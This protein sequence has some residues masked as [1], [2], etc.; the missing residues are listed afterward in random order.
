ME[1]MH[2][3][4]VARDN[5]FDKVLSKNQDSLGR[6]RHELNRNT[7]KI[8]Q[9]A[10]RTNKIEDEHAEHWQLTH[11]LEARMASLSEGYCKCGDR[12]PSISGLGTRQDP[13][14]V[15][16]DRAESPLE[17]LTPPSASP[18]E[19]TTPIPVPSPRSSLA[20]SDQENLRPSCCAPP[21][22][23]ASSRL[24]PI[25]ENEDEIAR[26]VSEE[27]DA[28]SIVRVNRR[29]PLSRIDKHPHRMVAGPSRRGSSIA[30]V[31][32][33]ELQRVI[34]QRERRIYRHLGWCDDASSSECSSPSPDCDTGRSIASGSFLVSGGSFGDYQEG[35]GDRHH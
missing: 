4:A 15:D 30:K 17:Y 23:P 9:W 25:E 10:E 33:R 8:T 35:R 34:R 27:L 5:Y 2:N 32:R 3:A 26:A 16:M 21:T 28:R 22:F 6:H 7:T 14:E 12:S 1:K 31:H 24:V 11:E 20:P 29:A 13:F 19:N 18:R